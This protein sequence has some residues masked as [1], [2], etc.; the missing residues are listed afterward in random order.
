[1]AEYQQR[2]VDID[3]MSYEELLALQEEIGE[4]KSR[5]LTPAEIARLPI[6]VYVAGERRIISVSPSPSINDI[7]ELKQVEGSSSS[8]TAE[9][10]PKKKGLFSA[11]KRKKKPKA[12]ADDLSTSSTSTGPTIST[13][14][15][16]S[17]SPPH[18][19][20]AQSSPYLSPNPPPL[21][22][23]PPGAHHSNQVS[24]PHSP[25]V[26]PAPYPLS[27]DELM[28]D[29]EGEIDHDRDMCC[30]CLELFN[31]GDQLM[32]LPCFHLGHAA[33]VERWLTQ[34]ST[35]P[36]CKFDVHSA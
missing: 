13:I 28:L 14:S 11:F 6:S 29:E 34:R 1:M 25:V 26:S 7:T 23:H 12:T 16:K 17:S 15:H 35:C 31:N 19:Q 8:S 4:V 18:V 30:I 2:V 10:K 9:A 33:E 21:P 27:E 32:R 3:R 5:G 22:K 36:I 24:A 20:H